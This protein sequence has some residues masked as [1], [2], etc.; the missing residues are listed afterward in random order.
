MRVAELEDAV[1]ELVEIP[2]A[3][4]ELE[5]AAEKLAGVP[6]ALAGLQA[7]PQ[8]RSVNALPHAAVPCPW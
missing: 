1:G 5:A 8:H 3:V 7:R 4:A 6:Q 2:P